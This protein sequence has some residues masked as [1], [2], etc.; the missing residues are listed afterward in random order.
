MLILRGIT[1]LKVWPKYPKGALDEP[2]ALQYASNRGY[3]GRVLD[4]SGETGDH[5]A[6]TQMALHEF[7]SDSTITALYG[8]SGGGYNVYHILK[9]LT[10]EQRGRLELVVVIGVESS[11]LSA[12]ALDS[13][14]F[15]A[16]WELVY[17]NDPP[18]PFTHID[19][20]RVLLSGV[21]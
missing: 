17:R 5:S 19:G 8:F 9:R 4:V 7:L 20:P 15:N 18:A 13:N 12:H 14:V 6:Q 10:E 21:H 1:N 11:K 2:P 3:V 16:H